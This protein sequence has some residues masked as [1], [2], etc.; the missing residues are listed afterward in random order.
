MWIGSS[1]KEVELGSS[2]LRGFMVHA[3]LANDIHFGPRTCI[4]A[5][6]VHLPMLQVEIGRKAEYLILARGQRRLQNRG[7]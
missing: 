2:S 1:H 5:M 3:E 6:V 7:R 4:I